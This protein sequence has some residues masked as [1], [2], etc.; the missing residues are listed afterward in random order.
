MQIMIWVIQRLG[1][2]PP[3]SHLIFA[4]CWSPSKFF[5]L[6]IQKWAGP[7]QCGDRHTIALPVKPARVP[8]KPN[9]QGGY[10]YS[11]NEIKQKPISILSVLILK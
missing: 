7:D 10:K 9:D 2:T 8:E 6:L 4:Q 5:G 3:Y 1:E 11:G